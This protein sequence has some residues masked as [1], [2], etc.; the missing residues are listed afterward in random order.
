MISDLQALIDESSDPSSPFNVVHA[1]SSTD[2]TVYPTTSTSEQPKE[3]KKRKAIDGVALPTSKSTENAQYDGTMYSNK[4]IDKM[5]E[6][7]KKEAEELAQLCVCKSPNIYL[8]CSSSLTYFV[9]S[10]VYSG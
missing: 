2:T 5:H 8:I 1:S 7:I 6:I 10:T 3:T 4:H 9:I